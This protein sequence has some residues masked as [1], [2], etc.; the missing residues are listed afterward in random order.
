[1]RTCQPN[2][3]WSGLPSLCSGKFGHETKNLKELKRHVGYIRYGWV[4][5]LIQGLVRYC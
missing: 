1:M 2:G 5:S 3:T 4:L